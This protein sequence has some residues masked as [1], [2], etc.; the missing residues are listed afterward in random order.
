MNKIDELLRQYAHLSICLT[1]AIAPATKNLI[2]QLDETLLSLDKAGW[3]PRIRDFTFEPERVDNAP[4]LEYKLNILLFGAPVGYIIASEIGSYNWFGEVHAHVAGDDDHASKDLL[5]KQAQNDIE[6]LYHPDT[7]DA[8][9]YSMV[10][11]VI[12]HLSL[13]TERLRSQVSSAQAPIV[14]L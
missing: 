2:I 5:P 9:K 7:R 14:E 4:D 11:F 3:M 12:W 8:A 13:R 1:Q 6:W 10:S